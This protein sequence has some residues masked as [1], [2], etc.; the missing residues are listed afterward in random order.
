[1]FGDKVLTKRPGFGVTR[2]SEAK[3]ERFQ[4]KFAETARALSDVDWNVE[5]G[6][7]FN[8]GYEGFT[9]FV[10]GHKVIVIEQPGAVGLEDHSV[11]YLSVT[12][13]GKET[14]LAKHKDR[15][16]GDVSLNEEELIFG[17]VRIAEVVEE[18]LEQ[19]TEVK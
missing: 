2:L 8:S 19:C 3:V 18:H 4:K 14:I 17:Y 7:I 13:D 6:E 11:G 9:F 5:P 10:N 16:F 12:V 15:R 1:M